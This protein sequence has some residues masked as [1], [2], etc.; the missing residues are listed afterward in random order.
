MRRLAFFTV[1]AALFGGCSS[2]G[3]T[4]SGSED[5]S[6]GDSAVGDTAQ[7]DTKSDGSGGDSTTTDAPTDT[8]GDSATTPCGDKTCTNGQVCVRTFTSGGPC[9]TCGADT[10][11]CPSGS[12]CSGGPPGC[13]VGDTPTYSYECKDLPT[14]CAPT[15]TCSGECGKALCLSYCPCESIS[16]EAVV[17]CHC[18]AP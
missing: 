16:L 11:V 2:S 12:H 17:T 18:L 3:S 1:I 15:L 10:G 4:S 7:L 14:A 5:S 9:M 13:C 6:P 8:S